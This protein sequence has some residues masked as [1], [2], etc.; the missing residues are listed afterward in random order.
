[1]FNELVLQ[2]IDQVFSSHW[3][4]HNPVFEIILSSDYRSITGTFVMLNVSS[5]EGNIYPQ[6]TLGL[7]GRILN[8][9]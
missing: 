4:P 7:V 5:V 6:K 9:I 3:I 2:I 1:M 8:R